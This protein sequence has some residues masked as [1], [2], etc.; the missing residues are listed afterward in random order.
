MGTPVT[1]ITATRTVIQTTAITAQ[2]LDMNIAM[3]R[4]IPGTGIT[5][6]TAMESIA[7]GTILTK[8]V[9]YHMHREVRRY[10]C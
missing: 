6:A 4:H 7:E 5:V 8:L 9:K 2:D 1:I 3:A 10:S